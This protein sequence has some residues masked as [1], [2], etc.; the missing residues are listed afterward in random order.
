[1]KSN[2][3]PW[4]ADIDNIKINNF[5]VFVFITVIFLSSFFYAQPTTANTQSIVVFVVILLSSL[6]LYSALS[7]TFLAVA[8]MLKRKANKW[9][10]WPYVNKNGGLRKIENAENPFFIQATKKA[11]R[12]FIFLFYG[13]GI[14]YSYFCVVLSTLFV[15]AGGM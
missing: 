8:L 9:F 2:Q 6:F 5:Y 12:A 11:N 15:K 1:M 13:W 14:F 4:L 10:F 7:K 3:P